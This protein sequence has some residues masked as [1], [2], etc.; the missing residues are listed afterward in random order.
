MIF[1]LIHIGIPGKLPQI[2]MFR[3]TPVS[4]WIEV[5][6]SVFLKVSKWFQHAVKAEKLLWWSVAFVVFCLHFLCLIPG[7]I[8]FFH[9]LI[10]YAC[11]SQSKLMPS[12]GHCSLCFWNSLFTC[13]SLNCSFFK[14]YVFFPLSLCWRPFQTALF[15]I[16]SLL[17]VLQL[18]VYFLE[19]LLNTVSFN[20]VIYATKF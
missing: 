18:I 20:H 4:Y 11:S 17:E 16:I 9:F 7:F 13:L 5:P 10:Y 1:N 15:Y 19:L 12:G 3:Y 6:V 14:V 8:H 2:L